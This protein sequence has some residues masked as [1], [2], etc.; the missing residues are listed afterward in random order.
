METEI[1]ASRNVIDQ[2]LA[3]QY[4]ASIC[5]GKSKTKNQIYFG[6]DVTLATLTNATDEGTKDYLY[7]W[8]C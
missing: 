4:G 8:D 1:I 6:I 5:P 3:D 2:L 7:G